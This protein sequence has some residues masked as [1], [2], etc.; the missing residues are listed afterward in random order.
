MIIDPWGTVIA[1]CRDGESVATADVDAAWLLQVRSRMP[2][3]A[4]RRPDLY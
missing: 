4:H 2:V 3:S 1:Q